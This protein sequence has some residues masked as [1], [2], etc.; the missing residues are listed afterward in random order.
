MKTL[1]WK[2]VF[3]SLNP[4]PIFEAVAMLAEELAFEDTESHKQEVSIR[5]SVPRAE[6]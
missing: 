2:K 5:T 6:R 3:A 1:T 4:S